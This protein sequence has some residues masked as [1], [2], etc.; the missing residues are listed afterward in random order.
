M[1]DYILSTEG[2]A[3]LEYDHQNVM[4]LSDHSLLL[5]KLPPTVS[6][7]PN[8]P[9]ATTLT[10]YKWEQGQSISDYAVSG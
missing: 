8:H 10:T 2:T 5:T 3:P 6:A 9:S 7:P 4:G 1:V